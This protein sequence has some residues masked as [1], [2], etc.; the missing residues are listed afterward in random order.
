M[1][2][3]RFGKHLGS[4]G[5]GVVRSATRISEQGQ[6]GVDERLAVKSLNVEHL[7]DEDA[8]ARFVREVRLL[9][10]ELDHPNVMP[11]IARN[12][13]A[14]PPWFVMPYAESNLADELEAGR[15][16]ERDW[17]V[18][19]FAAILEG[20]AHAHAHG[21]LHR[22]LKPPNVLFCGGI[23][24]VADFGLGKRLDA[25]ATKLTKTDMWMGT[26]PYM[27]PEQFADAKRVGPPADVY[28]L[29]KVLWEM[30]TGRVPDVLHVDLTA[31]PRDFQFFIEKCTRRDPDER[32]ADA[33]ETLTT[34]R[35]FAV[36][37][38]VLDPPMEAIEKLVAEWA[39][40]T[41]TAQK[42]KIVRRLDEH[43][44]RNASEEEL[45]FKVI[46]RLPDSLIDVYMDELHAAFN[47]MLHAYDRHISGGLP[48]SYCDTVARFYSRLF[49]RADDLDMRRL[50]LA[51][52]IAMGASHNRWSVGEITGVLLSK[53]RGVS[54]AMMAAEV[55]DADPG[56]A[57]WFWD[58][59]IKDKPLMRP[60]ADAF[61]RINAT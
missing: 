45:Y 19:T 43:L 58:P 23:P 32:F 31:V 17:V 42:R 24:K 14:S 12:L 44:A 33:A 26:E 15:A 5:F 7:D 34:F 11:V 48:F 20:M 47:T 41:N 30:L 29:G 61:E 37:A 9:D 27:S 54:D 4:G 13:S 28:A 35:M 52:L 38:D 6:A 1:A 18:E 53:I 55:I 36:G 3:F 25:N 46:P 2:R 49:H 10:E 56:H 21:V 60:I 51:R 22:D 50:I 39:D 8:V 40:A 16:G 59:W 57:Q